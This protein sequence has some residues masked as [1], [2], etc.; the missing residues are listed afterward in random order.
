MRKE[1]IRRMMKSF[2]MILYIT[3][4]LLGLAF[5]LAALINMHLDNKEAK[6]YIET[7]AS[8]SG[9]SKDETY[10]LSNEKYV[11]EYTGHY[12]FE[13]NGQ[14]Y[15]TEAKEK[16]SNSDSF[17]KTIKVKY[18][19]SNPNINIP[20]YAYY[21]DILIGLGVWVILFFFLRNGYIT[22]KKAIEYYAT[23]PD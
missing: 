18:D 19:P 12:S 2:Y 14:K 20:E 23:H 21:K 3:L 16:R 7:T 1:I 8:F 15:K 10:D 9:Y 11:T 22:E 5:I 4:F 17:K 6:G 13:V